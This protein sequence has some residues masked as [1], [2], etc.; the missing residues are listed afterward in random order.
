MAAN[1]GGQETIRGVVVAHELDDEGEALTVAI[2]AAGGQRYLV[3]AEGQ[4]AELVNFVDAQV[5]VTG[6]VRRAAGELQL[7]VLDYQLVEEEPQNEDG[8]EDEERA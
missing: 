4:G 7:S 8:D 6:T 2:V 1:Q 5:E 3:E